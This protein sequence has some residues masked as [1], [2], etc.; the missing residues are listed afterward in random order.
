MR[1]FRQRADVPPPH[2][3]ASLQTPSSPL[4]AATATGV[5]S[6]ARQ[7]PLAGAL[8]SRAARVPRLRKGKRLAARPSTRSTRARCPRQ[9]VDVPLPHLRA[10]LPAP[11]SPS[12]LR[13]PRA[14]PRMFSWCLLPPV[15]HLGAPFALLV[16]LPYLL[17]RETRKGL[18]APYLFLTCKPSGLSCV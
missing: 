17:K 1:H 3:R 5:F 6:P 10:P 13:N 16:S 9:R 2:L 12:S 14:E 18:R 11:P 4:L 15:A 8:S 7:A